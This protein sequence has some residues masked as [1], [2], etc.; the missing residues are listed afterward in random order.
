MKPQEK[1]KFKKGQ[2]PHNFKGW[3]YGGRNRSYRLIFKPDHLSAD[4]RGYIREHRLVMEKKLGRPLE[5]WEEVHHIN[6][7]GLDNRPENLM[8]LSHHDHLKLEHKLDNY[9]EH[10]DKLHKSR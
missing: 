4:S 6:H 8:I 7:N 10:L 5:K 3:R 9:T 1:Y 2:T